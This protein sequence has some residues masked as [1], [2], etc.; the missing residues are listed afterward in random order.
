MGGGGCG[1]KV[2][3]KDGLTKFRVT[4]SVVLAKALLLLSGTI[5]HSSQFSNF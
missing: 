2:R 5:E 4:P 1:S 3:S